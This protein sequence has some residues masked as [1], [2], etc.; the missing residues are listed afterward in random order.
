MEK[1]EVETKEAEKVEKAEQKEKS[2]EETEE[3][4]KEEK[5]EEEAKQSDVDCS[6]D[7]ITRLEKEIASEKGTAKT[8][9]EFLLSRFKEDQLFANKFNEK[10]NSLKAVMAYIMQE[11]QKLASN[12]S[13][14]IDHETVFGWAVHAVDEGIIKASPVRRSFAKKEKVEK[15]E[16]ETANPVVA[17]EKPQEKGQEK[18]KLKDKG[19]EQLALF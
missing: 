5:P 4:P 13:A 6:V 2:E 19:F 1:E 14:C 16:P 7:P 11:A 9:G 17:K 15:K 3:Q 8:I 12:G 18:P 10:K